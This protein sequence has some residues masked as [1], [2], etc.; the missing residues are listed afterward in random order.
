[1]SNFGFQRVAKPL[2]KSR[3]LTLALILAVALIDALLLAVVRVRLI[4][5]Q[6]Y[7]LGRGHPATV[8]PV[9]R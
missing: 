8:R 4:Q 1:V 6:S 3:D 2:R 7:D 5:G 9:S